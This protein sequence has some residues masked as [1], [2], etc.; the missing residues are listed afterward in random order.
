M[1]MRNPDGRANYEPN[2]WGRRKAARARIPRRGFRSFPRPIERRQAPLR[3]ESFADHYS[4]ARQ[5]FLSQTPI[6]QKHIADALVFELSQGGDARDP[7]ARRLHL[8]NIDADLADE[9]ADGLGLPTC[10]GRRRRR[11]PSICPPSTSSQHPEEW[12]AGTFEGRKLGMLLT[13][14]IDPRCSTILT[15]PSK[16]KAPS[17]E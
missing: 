9:V 10:P 11:A 3:P 12:A 16:P 2:S 4:Q 17:M 5:F 6:E 7:R 8:P 1:A 13:D 14:G 15:P